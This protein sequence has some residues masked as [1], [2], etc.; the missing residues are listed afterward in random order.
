MSPCFPLQDG[1]ATPCRGTRHGASSLARA[2]RARGVRRSAPSIWALAHG[3]P[4]RRAQYAALF[5]APGP[6]APEEV[7]ASAVDM[8][9]VWPLTT[10]MRRGDDDLEMELE[11]EFVASGSPWV[12]L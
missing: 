9:T 2:E 6:W 5:L 12:W 1:A 3:R 7:S 10:T 11:Q 4:R 8:P